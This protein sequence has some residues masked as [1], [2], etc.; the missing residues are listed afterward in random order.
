MLKEGCMK[1]S[2]LRKMKVLAIG[3][4]AFLGFLA[5]D[6]TAMAQASCEF[7]CVPDQCFDDC[8]KDNGNSQDLMCCG[9]PC[10]A[11]EYCAAKCLCGNGQIDSC[12]ECDGG[13][14][15]TAECTLNTPPVS[16]PAPPI[17]PITY[18]GQVFLDWDALEKRVNAD[19][20][21]EPDDPIVAA[22]KGITFDMNPNIA[23]AN[24]KASV[25]SK[26]AWAAHVRYFNEHGFFPPGQNSVPMSNNNC[27][28]PI[29]QG[30]I[31]MVDGSFVSCPAKGCRELSKQEWLTATATSPQICP[32][33]I[34]CCNQ[35]AP[36]FVSGTP[37][38]AYTRRCT[39]PDSL[40]GTDLPDGKY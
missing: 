2:F 38:P 9:K 8:Y 23:A 1:D 30:S 28:G 11:R 18:K 25:I 39:V 16:D 26:A 19:L 3:L 14:N 13:E 10:S 22:V 15:C 20:N 12:E 24:L 27:T 4:F 34:G 40:P 17:T 31:C 37:N 36:Q 5:V 29:T 6:R 7:D 21:I 32:T 33:N 35:D